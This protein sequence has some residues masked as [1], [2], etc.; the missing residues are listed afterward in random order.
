MSAD[1]QNADT[2]VFNWWLPPGTPRSRHRAWSGRQ[3]R[4]A[5]HVLVTVGLWINSQSAWT[6]TK[7]PAH[8]WQHR[9]HVKSHETDYAEVQVHSYCWN[10]SA[11]SPM[12]PVHCAVWRF[13]DVY[14]SLLSSEF[15]FLRDVCSCCLSPQV[16]W[17]VC[18]TYL[19]SGSSYVVLAVVDCPP[20]EWSSFSEAANFWEV[21]ER[22]GAA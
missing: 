9:S 4:F 13:L 8:A 20:I 21:A 10:P 15:R 5:W 16:T 2:F 14:R 6:S 1:L 18:S 12:C 7:K 17:A 19:F 11:D 3:G 22:E